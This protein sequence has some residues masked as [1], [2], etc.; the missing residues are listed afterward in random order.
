VPTLSLS[1]IEACF[2]I[3]I[4]A[5]LL[6]TGLRRRSLAGLSLAISS[7]PFLYRGIA[8]YWPGGADETRVELAG[9]RGIH[10]RESV[11][12]RRSPGEV[13]RFWRRLENLPRVMT[14][15]ESVTEQVD[16]RSHWVAKGPLGVNAS[17]DAEI[18]NDV[19]DRLIGWQSVPGSEVASAGSVT[20]EP[21]E[22]GQSTHVKVHLQ[23]SPPAGKAG[24]FVAS[25]LGRDPGRAI[26]SDLQRLEEVLS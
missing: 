24:A 2:S 11:T 4:G 9:D 17:W 12:V 7:A 19:E 3:G 25:L 14:H 1:G 16:G 8:H 6:F 26:H 15:L 13:Y 5:A 10:V 21:A 20:F 23:Y 18:I 22:D